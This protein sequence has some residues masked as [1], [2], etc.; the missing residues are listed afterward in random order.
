MKNETFYTKSGVRKNKVVRES[1]S[2]ISRVEFIGVG[3]RTRR[4]RTVQGSDPWRVDCSISMAGV[5]AGDEGVKERKTVLLNYLLDRCQT[6][7]FAQIHNFFSITES[8]SSGP[9]IWY[10]RFYTRRKSLFNRICQ[11][12]TSRRY[13]RMFS[14]SIRSVKSCIYCIHLVLETLTKLN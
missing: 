5:G 10:T 13:Q 12:K 4:R 3:D 2:P 8:T 1:A 7:K 14:L 9:I 11:S 6:D